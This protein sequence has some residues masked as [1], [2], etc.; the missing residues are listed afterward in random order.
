ML[1]MTTLQKLFYTEIYVFLSF[2]LPQTNL[3]HTVC[4]RVGVLAS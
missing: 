3:R 2:L 4:E 1:N